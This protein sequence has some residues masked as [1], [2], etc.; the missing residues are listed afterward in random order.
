MPPSPRLPLAYWL[1]IATLAL[2]AG[3]KAILYDTLDPDCF[4]HLRVADQLC[5][6]GIGPLVDRLSFA[7]DKTPWT[8]YSWLAEL[9]MKTVWDAGGYRAAIF[10]QA[11]ISALF[12]IV[13]ATTAKLNDNE[14]P[15]GLRSIIATAFAAFLSMAYLSF[16]P[17]ALAI[18]LLATSYLLLQRHRRKNYQSR[19]IW[20]IVP[21]TAILANVH[22][23]VFLIPLWIAAIIICETKFVVGVAHRFSV[24]GAI[25]FVEDPAAEAA[26]PKRIA[27]P[28]LKGWN[29]PCRHLTFLLLATVV[30]SCATPMLPGMLRAIVHYQFQDPMVASPAISEMQPFWQG[31]MGNISAILVA[32]FFLTVIR[33]RQQLD[34]A[35]W[36]L[37][38]LS[39]ILLFLHGR[40][41]PLFAI[42]AA[43]LLA[44]TLP[45]LSDTPL[46]RPAIP[47]A[48]AVI[49][50]AGSIRLVTA[51]PS[52]S[53]DL[54]QWLNRHGP[55]T[56]G[57]PTLA[58]D[59]IDQHLP[60][61]TGRLINEFT[62]GG[63]LAWRVGDRYQ[64]LLDGRTQLFSSEFWQA[65]YLGTPAAAQAFLA[66]QSADAALLPVTHSRFKDA[67]LTLG[68]QSIY[69]DDRAQ[70]LI[71]PSAISSTGF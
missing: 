69:A 60:P 10:A 26:S 65:T 32:G 63:Y 12:V 27:P 17:A 42:T 14:S 5:R 41:A 48:F 55:E 11:L 8:P 13:I 31:T 56:P 53:A 25:S 62:W 46:R 6:D 59:F 45:K 58:A 15:S 40:Y 23:F 52:G 28:P 50:I 7:S 57:Y 37:L 16:R 35:D 68:W 71:P 18:L 51:F 22:L 21:I 29:T 67:L 44:K 4:W 34:L 38:T 2:C 9:A 20:L 70:I 49:L 3:G 19:A 54:S 64:V 39:T 33:R 66:T 47:I 30:A 36:L 43:P 24:G 1:L 61:R